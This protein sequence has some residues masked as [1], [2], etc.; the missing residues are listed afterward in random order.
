MPWLDP[1]SALLGRPVVLC[2][3]QVAP[4]ASQVRAYQAAT[5]F[6]DGNRR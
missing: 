3:A 6:Y 5:V 2:K 1:H 4:S